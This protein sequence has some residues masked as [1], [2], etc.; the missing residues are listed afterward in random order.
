MTVPFPGLITKTKDSKGDIQAIKA[1]HECD[2]IGNQ[3][4]Y[5]RN[6]VHHS[7][8]ERAGLVLLMNPT[9]IC[10]SSVPLNRLNAS[11]IAR[12]YSS[13]ISQDLPDRVP[14]YKALL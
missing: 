7:Q 6:V 2:E 5:P 10:R 8:N 3:I 9:R 12:P 14:K 4:P 13:A 1:R 11:I